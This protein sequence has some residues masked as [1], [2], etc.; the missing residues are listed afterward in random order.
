MPPATR[1]PIAAKTGNHLATPGQCPKI[2]P[3]GLH[4]PV[5]KKVDPHWPSGC[6][7]CACKGHWYHNLPDWSPH[8][9]FSPAG[10]AKLVL[11]RLQCKAPLIFPAA[12]ASPFLFAPHPPKPCDNT[13]Y[14]QQG[15]YLTIDRMGSQ[16]VKMSGARAQVVLIQS[17]SVYTTYKQSI[18]ATFI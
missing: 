18:Y 16:I 12:V 1:V 6:G 11:D 3:Q 15:I 17:Y 5:A 10:S 7:G 8:R 4:V 2:T 13:Q 9:R 14:G